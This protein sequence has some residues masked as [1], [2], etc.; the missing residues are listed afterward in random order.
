MITAGPVN[1][2][3][4]K[5]LW[6]CRVSCKEYFLEISTLNLPDKIALKTFFA[7]S[8]SSSLSIV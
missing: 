5:S 7:D 6:A 1:N 3:A 2:L 8:T 4:S